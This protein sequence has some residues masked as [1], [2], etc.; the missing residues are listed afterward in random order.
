MTKPEK[1]KDPQKTNTNHHTT[2]NLKP[3]TEPTNDDAAAEADMFL[4]SDDVNARTHFCYAAVIE[5]T[6]QVYTDQLDKFLVPSLCWNNY[7]L[8]LYDVDYNNILPTPSKAE[9]QTD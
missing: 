2:S 8:V 3:S 9:Q 1:T 6:G 7:L 5:P 4:S